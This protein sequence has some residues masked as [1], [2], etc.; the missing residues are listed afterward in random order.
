MS[1]LEK[2]H[3]I[4][5]H[6]HTSSARFQEMKKLADWAISHDNDTRWN[7]WYLM[8]E[9]D[10]EKKSAI[11]IYIKW[12]LESLRKDFL[13]SE[14]WTSLHQTAVFLKSFYHATKKTEK[15][16]ATIDQVLWTMNIL[17]KHYDRSQVSS[18]YT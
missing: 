9:V 1:A 14:N 17:V 10:L 18:L 12:W 2:L 13:I 16:Y 11:N 3:N 15:N 7:S 4:V 8:L 6:T 5:V